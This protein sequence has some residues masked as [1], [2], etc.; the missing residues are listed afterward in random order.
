M[1][2]VCKDI[3]IAAP[4]E[5]VYALVADVERTAE[6]S[7]ECVGCR[8]LDGADGATVGARYRG[9]SRNGRRRWA[10]TS[11]IVAASP[12]AELAWDVTYL[13]RPVA[14]WHYRLTPL[15]DGGTLLEECVADHRERWLRAVSPWVTGSRDRAERNSSTIETSL[16]RIKTIAEA[17]RQLAPEA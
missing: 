15:D 4:P 2:T 8:W 7:P 5:V 17:S 12:G 3:A 1:G 11:T 6:W 9:T 10:T 16:T 14:R 13:R